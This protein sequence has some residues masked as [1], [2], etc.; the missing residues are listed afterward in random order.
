MKKKL[1]LEKINAHKNDS[2]VSLHDD[3]E[4]NHVYLIDGVSHKR[5]GYKSVTTFIGKFFSEFNGAMIVNKYY[6]KWMKDKE[7][8]YYGMSKAEIFKLWKDNGQIARDDG[9]I[10]HKAFEDFVNKDFEVFELPEFPNYVKWYS[11]EV[12]EP[13]RTEYTV[14]GPEELVIG[15]IDFI[16][17]DKNGDMCIVDYKRTDVPSNSSYG[18]ECL[19]LS[20][21]DNKA[22]KN[23]VQLNLYKYLLEKYY[24]VKIKHIYNLY[25]KND[26][27]KFVERDTINMQE[28]FEPWENTWI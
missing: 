16:Y 24:D 25:I 11:K 1:S 22:S 5:L 13:F 15:N 26:K 10:L 19:G 6:D 14:Y 18:K 27:C 4:N 12:G 17:K 23:T 20:L 8:K 9:T 21:P 28:V 3:Y 7:S 2:H